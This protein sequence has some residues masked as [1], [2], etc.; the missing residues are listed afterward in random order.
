M[1]LCQLYPVDRALAEWDDLRVELAAPLLSFALAPEIPFAVSR[2]GL[3]ALRRYADRHGMLI[4]LHV[5]ENH[6]DDRATLADYGR[7]TIPFLD[8]IGFWGPDVLAY[9]VSRCN[10]RISRSSPATTSRCRTTR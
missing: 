5:N 7:R 6:E 4:T 1:P 9:T 3:L 10:R 8:E 2:D